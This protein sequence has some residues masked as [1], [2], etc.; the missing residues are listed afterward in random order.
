MKA[1]LTLFSLLFFAASSVNAKSNAPEKRAFVRDFYAAYK[2]K[3]AERMAKFY[4]DDATFVDPS[5][6]LNLKGADQIRDLLTKA[7]AKYE[8]LDWEITHTISAGDDL[9]IEGVMVGKLPQKTVRVPFVSIFHFQ[10][11]K[12]AAQRDM[13]DMLH[14]FTQLGARMIRKEE[15]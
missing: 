10:N 14:Y 12:I 9:V 4:T 8:T 7:L 11:G 5:F 2:A 13:F 15:D 6:E 3:D 1:S